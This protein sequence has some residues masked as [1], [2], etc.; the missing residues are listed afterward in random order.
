MN[1]NLFKHLKN[2]P[3]YALSADE[4]ASMRMRLEALTRA[5]RAA[6]RPV[7]S[8]WFLLVMRPM[9]LAAIVLIISVSS[10]SVSFAASGALPGDVLYGV[11]VGIN[12]KVELALAGDAESK[13]NVLVRQAEER[14]K[15]TEVLAVEGELS[16]DVAMT[17]AQTVADN[18]DAAVEAAADLSEDGDDAAADGVRARISSAL[19][20]HS[21][22]LSAHAENFDDESGSTLRSLSFAVRDAAKKATLDAGDANTVVDAGR[23][24]VAAE[25]AH[26]RAKERL[27]S[28]K[29]QINDNGVPDETEAAL[30]EEFTR[31]SA[32]LDETQEAAASEDYSEAVRAYDDI[33]RRAYRALTLLR[34]AKKISDK[35]DQEVVIVLDDGDGADV[36]TMSAPVARQA[37]V[38]EPEAATLMMA[39]DA[40]T[41]V[42]NEEQEPADSKQ[43][44]RLQFRLRHENRD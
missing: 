18:V 30:S 14:L 32:S 36:A 8:P 24:R 28:L 2:D 23:V 1:H 38:A 9:P 33:D 31:L 44:P 12:E 42:Q 20:A 41:T 7:P 26:A 40:S 5:P 25:A 19:E 10:A 39:L 27:A 4:R 11:K 43:F 22:L 21:D 37:K 29:D 6:A 13:A 17:V 34:S 35:T 3:A 16:P 15:E